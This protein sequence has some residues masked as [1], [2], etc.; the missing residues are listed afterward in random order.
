MR[1]DL[2]SLLVPAT[3][4]AVAIEAMIVFPALICG[5]VIVRRSPELRTFVAGV[6]TITLAWFG[7][8]A[9]H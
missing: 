7:L 2:A 9:L 3:D 5:L 1:R 6:A 8:R 4:R